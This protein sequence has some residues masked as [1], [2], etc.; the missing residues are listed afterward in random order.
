MRGHSLAAPPSGVIPQAISHIRFSVTAQSSVLDRISIIFPTEKRVENTLSLNHSILSHALVFCL[1]FCPPHPASHPRAQTETE[2]AH[3][4]KDKLLLRAAVL[5][6]LAAMTLG[7]IGDTGNNG[8]MSVGGGFGSNAVLSLT[9]AHTPSSAGL[10]ARANSNANSNATATAL[11]HQF[12]AAPSTPSTSSS[13]SSSSSFAMPDASMASP[14]VT[15]PSSSSSSSSSSTTVLSTTTVTVHAELP[16]RAAAIPAAQ[17]QLLTYLF[18]NAN[19]APR[20]EVRVVSDERA[21]NDSGP[22]AGENHSTRVNESMIA[23]G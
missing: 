19:A 9:D 2:V 8:T 21:V 23:P 18:E 15:S 20:F 4:G 16:S 22:D 1:P 13:S 3:E 17:S 14:T 12:P 6:K 11:I 5:G 7:R 10:S